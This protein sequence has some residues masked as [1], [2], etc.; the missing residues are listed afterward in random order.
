MANRS[1]SAIFPQIKKTGT[2][3]KKGVGGFSPSPA[4]H[5]VVMVMSMAGVIFRRHAHFFQTL[6]TP[7]LPSPPLLITFGGN[8]LP[9]HFIF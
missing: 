6:P 4:A 9:I 5:Y 1:S 3:Q 7:F 8:Q 2:E